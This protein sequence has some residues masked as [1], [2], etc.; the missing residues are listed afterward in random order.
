MVLGRPPKPITKERI[1]ENVVIN[2][3]GCWEWSRTR[4]PA[5]YGLLGSNYKM[6][7]THRLAYQLWNGPIGEK[8]YVCH[9]CDNPPCCNPEH[10]FIGTSQDNALDMVRKG[11]CQAPKGEAHWKS[12]MTVEK[13]IEIKRLIKQKVRGTELA[14]MFEVS[15][16]VIS[17][18]KRGKTWGHV[19]LVE[20]EAVEHL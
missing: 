9:K 6:H 4:L 15:Q 12:I 7:Y 10:L 18:I 14:E 5:G 8:M 20:E 19:L 16:Q 1:S 2:E 3:N 13:V 11:R 17:D